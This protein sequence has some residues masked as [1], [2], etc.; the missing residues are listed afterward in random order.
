MGASPLIPSFRIRAPGVSRRPHRPPRRT[1]RSAGILGVFAL[2]L[3]SLAHAHEPYLLLDDNQDGTFTA[4]T[5]FSD[6]ASSAGLKLSLRE[7][8]TGE[9]LSEHVIPDGGKLTLKIPAVP[10]RVV[11]DGG[12]GHR[13]SKPGPFTEPV[14][15]ASDSFV[16]PNQRAP[17]TAES[18]TSAASSANLSVTTQSSQQSPSTPHTHGSH[19]H[20]PTG[21]DARIA[22][23]I[24]IFFVFGSLAFG[25]GYVA[26][27]RRSS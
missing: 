14:S 16:L 2:L 3:V 20:A 4:E 26:G 12:P 5:G 10:Y 25:L 11:F 1:A 18:S 22:I 19:V 24:G 13:V 9:T 8:T 6:R 7:R 17:L 21:D 27:R 23:I 15:P